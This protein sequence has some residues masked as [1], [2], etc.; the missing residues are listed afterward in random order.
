MNSLIL[1]CAVAFAADPVPVI[2]GPTEAD[3]YELVVLDSSTSE[4]EHRCWLV[5][6]S[7]VM[8]LA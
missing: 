6:T 8:L 1:W 4:A 2:V 7:G 3:P 5:D